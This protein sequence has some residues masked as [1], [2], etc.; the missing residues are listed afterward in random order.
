M[1]THKR[2]FD[3]AAAAAE[4][5]AEAEAEEE[6]QQQQQPPLPHR[7]INRSMQQ[8]QPL[9]E[10]LARCPIDKLYT[11]FLHTQ[12]TIT[13]PDFN[14]NQLVP[15][16]EMPL[17]ETTL[18]YWAVRGNDVERV[19]L[20]LMNGA[21]PLA[22]AMILW[23]DDPD[24]IPYHQYTA[25]EVLE[26]EGGGVVPFIRILLDAN[27]DANTSILPHN[28]TALIKPVEYACDNAWEFCIIWLI[29]RRGATADRDTLFHALLELQ[30]TP[31]PRQLRIAR[32]LVQTYGQDLNR[33]RQSMPSAVAMVEG[34]APT[35]KDT[36]RLMD[37]RAS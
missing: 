11:F 33:F 32:S 10:R 18:L 36:L 12:P 13:L 7:T 26:I 29:D 16:F 5:E 28:R 20:L 2:K 14:I 22:L 17:F 24:R 19:A 9:Y 21:D 6:Q 3:T 4:A 23:Y 1:S 35:L 34:R 15:L 8:Q 31:Q 27:I 30:G 25:L 37:A